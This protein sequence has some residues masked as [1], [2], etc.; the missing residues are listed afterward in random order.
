[1]SSGPT[2]DNLSE[3]GNGSGA[4]GRDDS[5]DHAEVH[6]G[7]VHS[8]EDQLFAADC[9]N[10]LLKRD[11][12]AHRVIDTVA[13]GIVL[14]DTTTGVI[15]DCNEE[16][17]KLCGAAQT[18]QVVGKT[19][20]M[21][22]PPEQPDGRP[23]A[24]VAQSH[25]DLA[26][27]A[28]TIHFDFLLQRLNG[29]CY[30]AYVNLSHLK[31]DGRSHVVATWIEVTRRAKAEEALRESESRYR[32]LVEGVEHDYIMYGSDTEGIINYVSPSVLK[33]LGYEPEQLLGRNW[34][35]LIA[36][37][38]SMERA[39]DYER[40]TL[41]GNADEAIQIEIYDAHE[42]KRWIEALMHPVNNNLGEVIGL[43]GIIKDITAQQ[44]SA[45]KMQ[46][47]A[48]EL[49]RRVQQRTAELERRLEFEDLLISLSTS[50]IN[51]PYDEIDAGL[52][53]AMQRIGEFTG[54]DRCFINSLCH[55]EQTVSLTHEWIADGISSVR[56]RMQNIPVSQLNWG[57]ARLLAGRTVHVPDVDA[58]PAESEPLQKLLRSLGVRS[59]VI[60][61][62]HSGSQ[63]IGLL[64]FVGVRTTQSWSEE[65]IDLVQ[66]LAEVLVNTFDR[67]RAERALRASEE[68]L[69][70][71]V[72]TVE[73]GLF[74]LDLTTGS[75]F[76]SD[77]ALR[78][79]GLADGD[80]NRQSENWRERIHPNDREQVE[81]ALDKHY[82]G[83]S[84]LYE[85]EYRLK[86]PEGVYVWRQARGR[87]VDRDSEGNPLR[88][89]GVD[90]DITERVAQREKNAELET[91]IAHLGRV[92]VMGE[93]VA[94]LAHEVNQPL[95]AAATF[96]AAAR[97]AIT[98][99]RPDATEK[100][101]DMMMRVSEQVSRAGDIIRRLRNFTRPQP[102]EF[103]RMN[104]N[105]VVRESVALMSHVSRR[106][107]VL[108]KLDLALTLPDVE[109]DI[110]QLQQVVVNLLQNAYDALA[111]SE[112]TS[113]T[114]AITTEIASRKLEGNQRMTPGVELKVA[115]NGSPAML[116][117][118]EEMF[119][120]FF[121]TKP[122]GMGIGLPLCKTIV[123]THRGI[124]TNSRNSDDGMTFS[125]WLPSNV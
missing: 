34:R 119:D 79:F 18:S 50:F 114:I 82:R 78:T 99:G 116:A 12:V 97:R 58:M 104:L 24:E 70:L 101:V 95:H 71:T 108:L 113:P 109:G 98:S 118:P 7:E 48:A 3:T 88:M 117:E 52:E 19:P 30:L 9:G 121:T 41:A 86:N 45:R 32:Q 115:D 59:V 60:V 125:V 17:L 87:V 2:D 44:S 1:M 120:T 22:Y 35:E 75:L 39:V 51:L 77:H 63:M 66:V 81:H 124:I 14:L 72:E 111:A 53:S 13:C 105:V 8:A 107:D 80:N 123:S 10:N 36:S 100:G 94:G 31:I 38:V 46:Q 15:A 5:S 26:V 25:I 103:E 106:S 57:I 91:Q 64:G 27:E 83:L 110:V 90:R 49:D 56:S 6:S 102:A 16:G 29:Q 85:V 62:M 33:V 47:L 65:D 11:D 67:H 74:D 84:P 28:G 89:L 4:R 54:V 20:H 112:S 43:E 61:P 40:R 92:A 42:Q 73:D 55:D 96:A 69:R 122:D 37:D 76:V 21:L 93:T 23:S 68:R